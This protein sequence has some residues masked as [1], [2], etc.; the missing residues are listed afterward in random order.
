M[1]IGLAIVLLTFSVCS[2]A[3]TPEHECLRKEYLDY[4]KKVSQ[5]WSAKNS[6]FEKRYPDLHQEFSYL[7]NEQIAHNRMQEITIEHL[8]KFHPEEF[9][10]GGSLFS[11]VPRYKHYAQSIYRELRLIPEFTGLYLEIESYRKENRMPNFERL[12]KASD[13]MSIELE[14]IP[15]VESAA[16]R[17]KDQ[18]GRMVKNLECGS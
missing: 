7:A 15:S 4:T 8:L 6:E 2:L 10:M 11:M 3:I 13:I 5:Y 12:T 16:Q 17:A 9:K 14:N 1:R 18:A